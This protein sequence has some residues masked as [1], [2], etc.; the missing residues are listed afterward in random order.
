MNNSRED[1]IVVQLSKA[2]SSVSVIPLSIRNTGLS[3]GLPT[4][5]ISTHRLLS[6]QHLDTDGTRWS[7]TQ[8]TCFTVAGRHSQ[9][10]CAFTVC[11]NTK[12]FVCVCV[13]VNACIPTHKHSF[14][15]LVVYSYTTSKQTGKKTWSSWKQFS[16]V[17][18]MFI[19]IFNMIVYKYV[20]FTVNITQFSSH[21]LYIYGLANRVHN[22]HGCP[23]AWGIKG[24]KW[25]SSL[26]VRG[27]YVQPDHASRL[28]QA[29]SFTLID[30]APPTS[31]FHPTSLIDSQSRPRRWEAWLALIEPTASQR[32][33]QRGRR[34]GWG[35]LFPGPITPAQKIISGEACTA[36]ME[37]IETHSLQEE[38]KATSAAALTSL[39][40]CGKNKVG[41]V[42]FGVCRRQGGAVRYVCVC[43]CRELSR[44]NQYLS[45]T[46]RILIVKARICF[47]S[48]KFKPATCCVSIHTEHF[49]CCDPRGRA[50]RHFTTL[51]RRAKMTW[52]SFF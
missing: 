22:K 3:E 24:S 38:I 10:C 49:C 30:P 12:F 23:E 13:C 52:R 21:M 46:L 40:N 14:L 25:W 5:W 2:D 37:A 50:P 7:H 19:I 43:V 26:R 45:H 32:V 11:Q 27:A 44:K 1:N 17:E 4:V 20:S 39:W 9:T 15:L 36:G 28:P 31:W 6:T 48:I 8:N 47:T 34:V 41:S 35:S 29:Q 16:S 51:E 33:T 42:C 18:A